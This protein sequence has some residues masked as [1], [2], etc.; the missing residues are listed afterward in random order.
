MRINLSSISNILANIA[1]LL[2]GIVTVEQS[3]KN[4]KK[5]LPDN[6]NANNNQ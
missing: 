3:D 5:A 1:A 2:Q 4:N 6:D